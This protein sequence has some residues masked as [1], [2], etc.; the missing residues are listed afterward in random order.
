MLGEELML[1]HSGIQL[2][3]AI[4]PLNRGELPRLVKMRMKRLEDCNC[5]HCADFLT[6]IRF[7]GILERASKGESD[8]VKMWTKSSASYE[9]SDEVDTTGFTEEERFNFTSHGKALDDLIEAEKAWQLEHNQ[10]C[11]EADE[12]WFTRCRVI[13]AGKK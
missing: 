9:P 11:L 12:Y 3:G 7:K 5:D 10:K 13:H 1:N 6:Q 2:M 4:L 8:G